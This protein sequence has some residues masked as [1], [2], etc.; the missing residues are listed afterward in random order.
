M[1]N[2]KLIY[3]AYLALLSFNQ[4]SAKKEISSTNYR[5]SF[6]KN[7]TLTIDKSQQFQ[8]IESFGASGCWYSEHIGKKWN[9]STKEQI[10]ELLFSRDTIENGSP[11][12]IGLSA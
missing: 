2:L 5:S 1:G 12:G 11:K 3:F 7:L 8:T 9:N 10:A 4:C 6:E